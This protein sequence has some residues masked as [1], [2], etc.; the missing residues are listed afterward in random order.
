MTMNSHAR[1]FNYV[2][3]LFQ[4]RYA[5]VHRKTTVQQPDDGESRWRRMSR[6]RPSHSSLAGQAK[7]RSGRCRM[8]GPELGRV[9]ISARFRSAE[10][11]E[12]TLSPAQ[13]DT[14]R[15]SPRM[16]I[17]T[18]FTYVTWYN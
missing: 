12:P 2:F 8:P 1:R 4:I 9:S 17:R 14:A 16:S 10:A 18:I 11:W 7:A 5:C 3:C 15:P 6:P 13:F